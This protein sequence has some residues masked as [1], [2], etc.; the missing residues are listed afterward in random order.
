MKHLR[1]GE[2]AP[3]ESPNFLLRVHIKATA[4]KKE[5]YPFQDT[6]QMVVMVGMTGF[7]PATSAS[8]T[9]RSTKLSHIPLL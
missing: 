2:L 8:R 4:N 5:R 3:R 1:G 7:E 6:P 9:Q